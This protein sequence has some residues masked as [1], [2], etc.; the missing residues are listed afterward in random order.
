MIRNYIITALRNILRHKGYS[1][2]N[3]IG[4][5]I[6]LACSFFILLWTQDEMSYDTF[7][8]EGDQVY[9]VMRHTVFGGKTGT[10]TSMPKPLSD[11]LDEEYPE[12]THTVLMSWEMDMV[13]T[14][15]NQAFRSDGRYFG[16]D[17]FTVFKFPLL[18][19]DPVSALLDPES[20]AISASL[21]ERYFGNNWH[22]RDDILGSIINI[23]HRLD[24]KVTAVFE[25]VPANSSLD[26]EF[27]LPMQEYISRNGWVEQW[28]NNGLR[29][30]ARLDKDADP[31]LVNEKIKDLI[32]EHIDAWESD[33]FLQPYSDMYLWSDFDNGFLVG[34]RIDYVRI[35]LF[36]AVF[37]ILIAAINF[38]NLATARS[39]Q[40]ALEI[41]I[42]KAVGASKT[43][44]A[45]QFMGES[46]LTAM[47]AF[48]IA[49]VLVFLLIPSFNQLTDKSI[50]ISLI[51]PVLWLQFSGLA[52]G[53]GLL[54]GSYPALHLSSFS[55]INVLRGSSGRKARGSG[56]RKGLVVFQF[57]MSIVLIIGTLTVYRQLNYIR[58]KDLGVDRD[59]TVYIP[60]EGNIRDQFD[61]F[62]HE[63]L[64]KPGITNVTISS[65]NPIAAGNNTIGVEWDGKIEGDNTLY[66]IINTG[67]DFVETMKIQLQSGR[68]FSKAHRADST[69]YIINEK[70]AQAMGM[71]TP[72]GKRLAVWEREG[73]VIGVVKDFH[74]RSLYS[75]IEPVILR[76]DPTSTQIVFI[77]IEAGQTSEGL[78]ALET[79]FNKFN[80]GYPYN[81]RFLDDEFEQTYRSETV[82]GKLANIFAM[83][84]IL[85]ACLGLLGLASFTAEQRSKEIAIRKVL[86]SSV[87]KIIGLL[88]KEFILLVV[89]AY[90][91][92]LPIAYYLMNKWLEDFAFHT[93]ISLGVVIGS[94]VLVVVIAWLNVSYQSIRAAMANPV[95]S[96]RSE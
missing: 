81:C 2:I 48:A 68:V 61:A 9:R 75:E 28:G 50:S 8:P 55:V 17:F 94:G 14:Y 36:V 57:I 19:G 52:V 12:I 84:A 6:G 54:A 85:I 83:L 22:K 70:A 33:V 79:V 76:L 40:R 90:A 58:N 72:L 23:D 26:F 13:L 93:Q 31:N 24:A 42:R 62:K 49:M 4:L 38:M 35:F 15:D 21:A 59:N 30:F 69:N 20:I 56:L 64:N 92:A 82:I 67:Y 47:M 37:I 89:G 10:S 63:L 44:L 7:L 80:P 65:Q 66:T 5:A 71:D 29:M 88:S 95:V 32:D 91:V 78:A 39:T 11:V 60:L 51:D 53:T 73:S 25:D 43:S 34:G 87:I 41:G 45:R 18:Y 27:I 86:G 96:L 74:M 77:R 16:S 3:I 1:F 46:I